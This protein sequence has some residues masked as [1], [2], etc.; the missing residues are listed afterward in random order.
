MG[1]IGCG[2]N[3]EPAGRGEACLALGRSEQRP[4]L[5]V[6]GTFDSLAGAADNSNG[7]ER[8]LP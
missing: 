7:H 1:A 8:S 2:C 3:A 4:Y 5:T 6:N